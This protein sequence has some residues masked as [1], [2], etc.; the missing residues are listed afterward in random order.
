[1][2]LTGRARLS[3]SEKTEEAEEWRARDGGELAGGKPVLGWGRRGHGER[4]GTEASRLVGAAGRGNA[5][6]APATR[7]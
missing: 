1:L 3:V 2:N 7:T 4:E 5:G 6:G